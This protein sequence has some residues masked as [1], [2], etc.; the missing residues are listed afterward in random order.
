MIKPLGENVLITAFRIDESAMIMVD[1]S[2]AE[3]EKGTVIE[4]GDDV[5]LVKKGDIIYF[6]KYSTEPIEEGKDKYYLIE[7]KDIKG[8]WV[9]NTTTEQ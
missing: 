9:T 5:T 6:K 4:I 3:I 2:L 1:D 7:E 8:L